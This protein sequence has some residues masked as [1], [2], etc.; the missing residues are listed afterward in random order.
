VST[1][2]LSATFHKVTNCHDDDNCY[3]GDLDPIRQCHVGC[4]KVHIIARRDWCVKHITFVIFES[5]RRYESGSPCLGLALSFRRTRCRRR[6]MLWKS[7]CAGPWRAFPSPTF[8][9]ST[10]SRACS[11]CGPSARKASPAATVPCRC[12][13]PLP[14]SARPRRRSNRPSLARRTSRFSSQPSHR[15]PFLLRSNQEWAVDFAC[16]AL[17]T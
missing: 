1:D 16:D 15:Q 2:R 5:R 14:R 12:G 9:I 6:R 11:G 8:R 17:A 3:Y 7:P 4:S 10:P 13:P